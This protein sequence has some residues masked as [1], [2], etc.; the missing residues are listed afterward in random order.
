MFAKQQK[1]LAKPRKT[2]LITFYITNTKI[3]QLIFGEMNGSCN[4]LI[5]EINAT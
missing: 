1:M 2:I 5:L 4:P 3:M